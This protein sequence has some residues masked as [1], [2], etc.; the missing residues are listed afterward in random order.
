MK[1]CGDEG[2][3]ALASML[4]MNVPLTTLDLTRKTTTLLDMVLEEQKW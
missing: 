4:L 2:A 3:K 1:K